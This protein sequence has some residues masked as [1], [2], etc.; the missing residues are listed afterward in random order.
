MFKS[1][2]TEIYSFFSELS[3]FNAVMQRTVG[4][5]SK[6][7]LF[8]IVASEGTTFPLTTYVLGERTPE[9]KDRSLLDI[10]VAFWFDKNAYD[11]CCEF[12][13]AMHNKIAEKYNIL[14]ASVE[15]NEDSFTYS[16][17]IVFNLL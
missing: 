2:S 9:T 13:D 10:Y 15:Y 6:T 1:I 11:A 16:G 12:T 4:G 7:F 5:E 8:P 3:E 17:L 14:S